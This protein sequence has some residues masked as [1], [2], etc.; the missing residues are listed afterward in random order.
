MGTDESKHPEAA[1]DNESHR[2]KPSRAQ[3]KWEARTG[4]LH[5]REIT[6]IDSLVELYNAV[7][8]PILFSE[9][10]YEAECN[11]CSGLLDRTE[12]DPKAHLMIHQKWPEW[13]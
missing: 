6:A 13:V 12:N 2:T 3:R 5:Q 8:W 11:A 9:A 10:K 4:N 1:D 7:H